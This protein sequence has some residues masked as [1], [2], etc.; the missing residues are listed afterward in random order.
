MEKNGNPPGWFTFANFL[1]NF[2]SEVFLLCLTYKRRWNIS[3]YYWTGSYRATLIF[4]QAYTTSNA[5]NSLYTALDQISACIPEMKPGLKV[6]K[7]G[8]SLSEPPLLILKTLQV[9]QMYSCSC[10]PAL[11]KLKRML[12]VTL[13]EDSTQMSTR[14]VGISWLVHSKGSPQMSKSQSH[15]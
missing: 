10:C 14:W 2:P 11:E 7:P 9:I 3:L 4:S 5:V 6:S 13:L 15:T 1:L 12:Q 8:V